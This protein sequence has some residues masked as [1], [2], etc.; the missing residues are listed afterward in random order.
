[1]SLDLQ[2]PIRPGLPW[3]DDQGRHIQAHGGGIIQRGD[4]W[5]WFGEDR[6]KGNDPAL[7]HVACYS[8][9]DLANWEYRNRVLALS[10]PE[11]IGHEWVLERPKVYFNDKTEKYVLYFHV[12]GRITPDHPS[13]YSVARVGVAV[14]DSIDGDYEYL[15]SFRPLGKESRDIGQFI[16][17]DGSPYLIFESRPDKAFYIAALS[18]DYLDVERAVAC[19]RA[20]LEGGAIVR[21]DGL[22]YVIGSQLTGWWPNANKYATAQKLEGPWSDFKDFA[23]AESHTF[24]SQ[25]SNLIKINGTKSTAVIY[26]G[27][28]WRPEEQ[29]DSRYLWM[30]FEIGNGE[31]RLP[32]PRPWIIDV[33]TGE[34]RYPGSSSC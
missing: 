29:W 8:S 18:E 30:P 17:D 32:V 24:M 26:V 1:M 22:Y 21:Y 4:T 25:S 2:T 31:L 5:Y 6:S 9:R 16:D 19:I 3:L 27:D 20:P 15:R 12:D 28:R 7:R 23:P 13:R 14:C 33:E 11:N 10:D 34:I